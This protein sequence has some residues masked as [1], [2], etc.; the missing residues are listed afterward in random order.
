VSPLNYWRGGSRGRED[1]SYRKKRGGLREGLGEV[2]KA[3]EKGGPSL[4]GKKGT[5]PQEKNA[6][7]I[8]AKRS[9]WE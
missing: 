7:S 1:R 3:F 8:T 9:L 6:A 4:G 2:L 5:L